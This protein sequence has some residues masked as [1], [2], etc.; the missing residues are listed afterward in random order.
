MNSMAAWAAPVRDMPRS[1]AEQIYHKKYALGLHFDELQPGIDCVMLDYGINSGV[2]R[3]ILVARALV[4]LPAGGMDKTLLDHLANVD[5]KTFVDK[6]CEERL[7]FMH[8]IRG[9]AS[10]QEFGR[11]W[12]DRVHDLNVYCDH[13]AA[14][15]HPVTSAPEAVDLAQVV[16]PKA[17]HIAGDTGA[18]GPAAVVG[19]AGGAYAAGGGWLAVGM[20]AAAALA[21]G[22]GYEI[23][24]EHKATAANSLVHV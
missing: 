8:A 18:G 1:E 4:G 11:G 16:T 2:S 13:L 3:P 9:G 21:L 7:R 5:A 12:G 23:W 20:C 15:G 24:Q 6:M 10:W 17:Q 14:G 22:L 19:A